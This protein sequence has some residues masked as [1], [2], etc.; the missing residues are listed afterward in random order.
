[1]LY[2]NKWGSFMEYIIFIILLFITNILLFLVFRINLKKAKKLQKDEE[3]EK[4]TDKF[5]ENVQIAEEMLDML[6]NN[7]VK[8][9]QAKDTSASLYI[10][11]TNKISI[12]DMKN[13]YARI[14]TIAHECL[15]S[16]QDRRLLLF[17]FIFSNINIIYFILISVLTILKIV[18]G[19][20]FQIAILF[21]FFVIQFVVRSYLEID[22][23]T[24][25]RFLAKEYME[26]KKLI[27]KKGRVKLLEKYKEINKIGIPFV[28]CDLLMNGFIRIIIYSIICIII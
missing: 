15:H 10:A 18:K 9:E 8:I 22:A 13:N 19:S 21:L 1:M 14:Q 5:P 23:M 16:C 27:P 7:E 28:I 25:S 17:N 26:K 3:L 20:M 24:R 6:G 11:V 12:A 4:L 2:K